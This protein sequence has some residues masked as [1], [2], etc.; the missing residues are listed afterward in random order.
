MDIEGRK[1]WVEYSKAKDEMFAH[2]DTPDS[3]WWE[4]E[5]DDKLKARVNCI[6][7]LVGSIPY[8]ERPAPKVKLGSRPAAP[9][10]RRP[11]L[12]WMHFVPDHAAT[13]TLT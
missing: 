5:A 6:A 13:I 10:Y 2:C 3:P 8:Q 12:K 4:V 11:P 1:R 9:E 7:H